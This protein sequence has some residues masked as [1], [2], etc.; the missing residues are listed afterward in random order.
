M[1]MALW[2]KGGFDWGNCIERGHVKDI[3]IDDTEI[4]LEG[5]RWGDGGMG[6]WAGLI[7]LRM[8][9]NGG[10]LWTQLWTYR[11]NKMIEISWL[12]EEQLAS[13]EGHSS[14]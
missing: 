9:I 10:L 7:W 14:I 8:V 1:H 12:A 5:M 13:Q 6:V 4:D 2:G 11:Y 3:I